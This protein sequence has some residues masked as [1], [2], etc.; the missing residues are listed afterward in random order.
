MRISKRLVIDASVASAAGGNGSV[1][2]TGKK[3]RDL[4]QATY[5]ACHRLVMTSEIEKEWKAEASHYSTKWW[6]W[7]KNH[8]KELWLTSEQLAEVAV[9][10][11]RVPAAPA[12][13][14]AMT[15]DI[16]L[17]KAAIRTDRILVSLDD[18]ARR[19]FAAASSV[20]PVLQP[21]MWVNP[22]EE[23]DAAAWVS[24][25]ACDEARRMLSNHLGGQG[26][27]QGQG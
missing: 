27:A 15:Q 3:C 8:T 22:K 24:K 1:Q 12:E 23:A 14:V 11:G 9:D 16:H 21:V 7:M 4:L 17:V 10:L 13:A 5:R 19:L 6:R 18:E 25:G 2:K 26:S 20:V